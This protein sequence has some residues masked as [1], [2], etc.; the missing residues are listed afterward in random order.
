M[1]SSDAYG[2][3]LHVAPAGSDEND[4]TVI[5][6]CASLGRAYAASHAD[7]VRART[8]AEQQHRV[9]A[10]SAYLGAIVPESA[11]VHNLLGIALA[12]KGRMDDAIAEFRQALRLDPES[13]VTYWHLGAALASRGARQ[14]A[15]ESL[16]RSVRL[17]PNNPQARDDLEHLLASDRGR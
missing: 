11:D 15:I 17:D 9:I 7:V 1:A 3:T 6:P 13:A 4:C 14:E 5:A 8:L 12:T 2:A 10:G 16:R